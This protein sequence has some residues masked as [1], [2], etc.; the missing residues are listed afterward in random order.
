LEPPLLPRL[1]GQGFRPS[2]QPTSSLLAVV[3]V[4]L[5]LRV[6]VVVLAVFKLQAYR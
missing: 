5:F 6:V 1:V 2:R 3:V 4:A